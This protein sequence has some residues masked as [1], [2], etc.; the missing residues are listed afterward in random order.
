MPS[1]SLSLFSSCHD[2]I[3][4]KTVNQKMCEN[5]AVDKS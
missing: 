5:T 2:K 1:V 4:N 3:W